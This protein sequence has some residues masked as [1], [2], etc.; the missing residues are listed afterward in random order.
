MVDLSQVAFMDSSG[1][2]IL[3]SAYKRVGATQGWLRIAGVDDISCHPPSS[4]H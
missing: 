4:R 3:I 2:N 1:I